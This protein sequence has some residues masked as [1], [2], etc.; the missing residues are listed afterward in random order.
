MPGAQQF[1][2]VYIE[3]RDDLLSLLANTYVLEHSEILEPDINWE[4]L[5]I[6]FQYITLTPEMTS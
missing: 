3:N 2:D 6:Y 5:T 1:V 4:N